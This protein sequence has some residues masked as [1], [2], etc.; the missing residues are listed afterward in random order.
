MRVGD[1]YYLKVDWKPN[2]VPNTLRMK[3]DMDATGRDIVLSL[4]NAAPIGRAKG[5]STHANLWRTGKDIKANWKSLVRCFNSSDWQKFQ[6]PGHWNDMDMLQVGFLG[7]TGRVNAKPKAT[8]LKPDE[9][10]TQVS[11]W[12]LQANPLLLSCYMDLLDEFTLSLLTNDEILDVN[13]DPAGKPASMLVRDEEAQT[14]IWIKPLEDG[15]W[16]VGFF[17]RNKNAQELS[18]NLKDLGLISDAYAVRDLWRQKDVDDIVENTLTRSVNAHG[19][20]MFRISK[21]K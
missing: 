2:D 11:M 5:L 15:G 9:Q 4:S 21:A 20:Y 12:S 3:N 16:A 17:N 1:V 8:G 18:L 13:Q 6:S 10:Y 14:E 19:V 7:K